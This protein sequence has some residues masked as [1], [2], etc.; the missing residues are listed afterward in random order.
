ML[1]SFLGTHKILG[2]KTPPEIFFS[3]WRCHSLLNRPSLPVPRTSQRWQARGRDAG[4]CP[5]AGRGGQR[6]LL[7]PQSPRGRRGP[8]GSEE[9]AA[10]IAAGRPL[11]GYRGPAAAGQAGQARGTSGALPPPR[12]PSAF[13]RP[14]AAEAPGC[15]FS[16]NPLPRGAAGSREPG[17]AAAPGAGAVLP[18]GRGG[19]TVFL[20]AVGAARGTRCPGAEEA[21]DQTGLSDAISLHFLRKTVGTCEQPTAKTLFRFKPSL[22]NGVWDSLAAP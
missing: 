8:G 7:R 9:A 16:P 10:P 21:R 1:F 2:W 6:R 3:W 14:R 15:R 18:P 12:C 11:G 5:C 22:G 13:S 17:G 4:R 19:M 20:G